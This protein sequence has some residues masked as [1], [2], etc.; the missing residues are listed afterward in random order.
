[1][2]LSYWYFYTYLVNPEKGTARVKN[3][4]TNSLPF[5]EGFWNNNPIIHNGKVYA[6]QN[7]NDPQ[8]QLTAIADEK[9]VLIFNGDL[10]IS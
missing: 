3:H 4:V 7:I 8:D 5:A 1:M 10:W 2:L 9:R 6:L